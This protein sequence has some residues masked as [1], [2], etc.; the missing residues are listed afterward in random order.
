MGGHCWVP[1]DPWGSLKIPP[2]SNEQEAVYW[3]TLT[4]FPSPEDFQPFGQQKKFS[5]VMVML[6]FLSFK[7]VFFTI[8]VEPIFLVMQI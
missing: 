8:L 1:M 4:S 2:Q 3:D 7:F 6:C 5:E